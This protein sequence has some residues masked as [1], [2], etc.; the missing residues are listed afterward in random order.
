MARNQPPPPPPAG[1]GLLDEFKKIP[2]VTRTLVGS[3][4]AVTI[5]V[6]LQLVRGD[7]IPFVLRLV[8]RGQLWRIPT[9]FFF[10]GTGFSFIFDLVMLY[11][12]SN[13]LESIW[14]SN[15]SVD[16]AWQL[17]LASTAILGLNIP[18]DTYVHYRA[19]LSCLIYLSS[20]L[21]PNA[22]VSI[23]GLVS[24]KAI[25]FP[26]VLLAFDVLQGGPQAAIIPLTGVMVGHLWYI[27]EWQEGGPTRPGGG[28]GAVLGSAPGWLQRLLGRASEPAA[29]DARPY[30]RAFNPSGT[31]SANVSAAGGHAW[32]RG[33]R[34]GEQ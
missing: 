19:L 10:G 29:G 21:D 34:L 22:M 27:L 6:I 2:P 26:F 13:T 9:S 12:S 25:Y 30:G 8:T 17:F 11:R 7:R 14:Y 31:T 5:P 15:R 16:Y 1:A 18:L 3:T 33:Q 20:R 28:R 23:L 4:V 32:G 24:V